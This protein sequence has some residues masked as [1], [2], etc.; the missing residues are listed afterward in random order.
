MVWLTQHRP[1]L[2]PFANGDEFYESRYLMYIADSRQQVYIPVVEHYFDIC[3]L[4]PD[5]LG[6]GGLMGWAW[7]S[8][9]FSST[10]VWRLNGT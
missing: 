4:E 3:G 5:R 9:V 10:A 6:G 8:F 7:I 1:N 2:F